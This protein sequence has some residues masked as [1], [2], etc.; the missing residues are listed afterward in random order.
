[1]EETLGEIRWLGID[2]GA[3]GIDGIEIED[4]E[5]SRSFDTARDLEVEAD[6]KARTDGCV[7]S[8]V[9]KE[10]P[11]NLMTVR[12]LYAPSLMQYAKTETDCSLLA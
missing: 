2:F 6:T 1:M 4:W 5:R 7:E 11:S 8:H 12:I 10:R 3:S 9:Y